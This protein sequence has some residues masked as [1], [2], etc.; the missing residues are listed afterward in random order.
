MFGRSVCPAS[1]ACRL[2]EDQS[3]VKSTGNA[4][5]VWNPLRGGV[6]T[7]TAYKA[8]EHSTSLPLSLQ[9]QGPPGRGVWWTETGCGR[10]G[11]RGEAPGEQGLLSAA[12]KRKRSQ[13]QLKA[14]FW[15]WSLGQ[16]GRSL[17]WQG[18]V[19]ITTALGRGGPDVSCRASRPGPS[20]V[21]LEFY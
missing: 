9:A 20:G 10:G 13:V 4:A 14:F 3:L 1:R 16:V 11:L 17:P 21:S 7:D 2:W 8:P 12:S 19:S 18:R 5:G 6:Q 15:L